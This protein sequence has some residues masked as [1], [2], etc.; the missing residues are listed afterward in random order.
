MI[1]SRLPDE[2]VKDFDKFVS[3]EGLMQMDAKSAMAG[4]DSKG[5]YTVQIR[6]TQF[7]FCGA[8]LAPLTGVF[9]ENYSWSVLSPPL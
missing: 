7:N 6:E 5:D 8:E 1:H 3:G 4:E 2:V 9:A